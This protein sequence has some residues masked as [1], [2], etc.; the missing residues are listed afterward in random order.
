M[1]TGACTHTHT[2]THMHTQTHTHITTTTNKHHAG[3]KS[4]PQKQ[5]QQSYCQKK[6]LLS[7]VLLKNVLT[8]STPSLV[9][10]HVCY[11]IKFSVCSHKCIH[12][13]FLLRKLNN[14]ITYRH[15]MLQAEQT[16]WELAFKMGR[17]RGEISVLKKKKNYHPET[18]NMAQGHQN[19][20]D[21]YAKLH[22]ESWSF[23]YEKRKKKSH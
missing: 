18:L 16:F 1:R 21:E 22:R 20:Y 7:H 9:M 15:L 2:H 17:V 11:L 12:T 14:C 5:Q 13:L 19:W 4:T 10:M 3:T 8:V 6:R 23:Q